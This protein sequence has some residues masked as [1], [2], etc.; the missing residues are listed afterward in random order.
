MPRQPG[1]TRALFLGSLSDRFDIESVIDSWP[2]G[3]G[4]PTLAI[5]GDGDTRPLLEHAAA[6]NPNVEVPGPVA[7]GDVP[8]VMAGF[9]VGLVPTVAGF[10]TVLSNKVNEYLASGLFIVHSLEDDPAAA[11]AED[12]L[13][14]RCGPGGW[15]DTISSIDV[16]LL[17]AER[18]QRRERA[19]DRHGARAVGVLLRQEFVRLV[20]SRVAHCEGEHERGR[21]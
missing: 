7:A 14:Q 6:S 16:G 1:P 8:T 5:I 12:H 15:G 18:A 20:E 3:D 13:G 10:G 19:L 11:L 21:Q 4:D 9:D 17:D 2:D